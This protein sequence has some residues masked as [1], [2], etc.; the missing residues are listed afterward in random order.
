MQLGEMVHLDAKLALLAARLGLPA[1]LPLA[2]SMVLA[3][4]RAHQATM[5]TQDDDFAGLADVKYIAKKKTA[6]SSRR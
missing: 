2:D 4:A 6:K 3:T 5:W 1:K